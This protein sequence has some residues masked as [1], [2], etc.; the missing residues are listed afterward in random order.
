MSQLDPH[1][2]AVGG[3]ADEPAIAGAIACVE[4]FT[5]RFNA[6]DAEGMDG[7]LHFPHLIL[8][9]EKLT[10]WKTPG[11]L[12]PGFFDDLAAGTGWA[13]STYHA[14]RVVLAAPR[15]VHLLIEYS[16]DRDDGTI[17]SRHANMWIVTFEDGRWGVKQRSY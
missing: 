1:F 11:Q 4:A 17:I 16:R 3:A 2:I 10:L 6:R 5:E 15:K 14:K 13:R 12:P 8:A 7:L 9:G